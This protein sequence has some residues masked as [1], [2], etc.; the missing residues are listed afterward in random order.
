MD[1]IPGLPASSSFRDSEVAHTRACGSV[2]KEVRTA[3]GEHDA[4][5]NAT[6]DVHQRLGRT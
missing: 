6:I 1:A 2:D 3:R 5:L 4:N